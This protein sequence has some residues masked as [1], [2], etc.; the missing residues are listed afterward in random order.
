MSAPNRSS[1][2]HPTIPAIP[3]GWSSL[4]SAMDWLFV[5]AMT[6]M[7]G[8]ILLILGSLVLGLMPVAANAQWYV[9]IGMILAG[10]P[11]LML[12]VLTGLIGKV[13]C[14]TAPAETGAAPL[15]WGSTLCLVLALFLAASA[16]QSTAARMYG[17]NSFEARR[18]FSDQLVVAMLQSLSYSLV[19]VQ[20]FSMVSGLLEIC[21]LRTV[22]VYLRNESLA[23]M[24]TNYL[25]YQVAM[26]ILIYALVLA[27]IGLM[28]FVG[29]PSRI[30]PLDLSFWTVFSSQLTV[31]ALAV[32]SCLWYFRVIQMSRSGVR[33]FLLMQPR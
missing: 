21:F 11:L 3:V 5:A 31:G 15:A 20:L 23:R 6:G 25:I 30:Q 12:S 17:Q 16:M 4:R 1:A 8:G 28:M 32:I 33:D 2:S 27:T 9:A 13:L 18:G 22:A 24:A 29:T 7:V 26:P 10:V 19:G 14:C